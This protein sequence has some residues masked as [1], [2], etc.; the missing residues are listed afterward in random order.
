MDTELQLNS[1]SNTNPE[2]IFHN[3]IYKLYKLIDK[4][5]SL[6][7]N[8]NNHITIGKKRKFD[9]EENFFNI[10]TTQLGYGEISTASMTQLF[11]FL[12]NIDTYLEQENYC[13][14]ESYNLTNNSYFLDIGSGFGKPVFHCAYQAGCICQGIEVVPARVE[15][16]LDFYFSFVDGRNILN[17]KAK[18]KKNNNN[19]CQNECFNNKRKKKSKKTKNKAKNNT[20]AQK[21]ICPELKKYVDFNG[22]YKNSKNKYCFKY[23][24]YNY[25]IF[26]Y[27]FQIN[28]NYSNFIWG[29]KPTK[30]YYDKN[31]YNND[32]DKILN[33]YFNTETQSWTTLYLT[34]LNYEIINHSFL[35]LT[36]N[37]INYYYDEPFPNIST[38]IIIDERI[39]EFSEKITNN[40]AY[41]ITNN[42][43]KS[44]ENE[45]LATIDQEINP[46]ENIINNFYFL[47]FLTYIDMIT[48]INYKNTMPLTKKILIEKTEINNIESI[49][50]DNEENQSDTKL[51]DMKSTDNQS[52]S[53]VQ[54]YLQNKL[55]FVSHN[56][57]FYKLCSFLC[58]DAT[59]YKDYHYIS[60]FEIKDEKQQTFT[61]IY[62]YNKL[63]GDTCKEKICEIL[64][65]TDWKVLAWYTNERQ[66]YQSG[67]ENF[68]YVTSFSMTSTGNQKFSCYVY[69][70]KYD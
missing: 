27:D 44:Y 19:N 38:K 15:F 32:I 31:F 46:N 2:E 50:A 7:W 18:K 62:S 16:C 56:P 33:K 3:N 58:N 24:W 39:L 20:K 53:N 11:N 37:E 5:S 42:L 17:E 30:I 63:M 47:D 48:S 21:N 64:N 8:H 59:K 22:F 12:M 69:I 10:E 54:K 66:T 52:N 28:P 1:K 6:L 55:T 40:I 60:P 36:D 4:S 26:G 65:K 45:Y 34:K 61:H 68:Q 67:L 49:L 41:N 70:K 9:C 43:F 29:V 25:Y 14:T 13:L 23:D 35:V 57:D 51:P